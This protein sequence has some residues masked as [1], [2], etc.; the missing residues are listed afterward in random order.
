M[1]AAMIMMIVTIMIIMIMIQHDD[2]DEMDSN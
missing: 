1:I 2:A